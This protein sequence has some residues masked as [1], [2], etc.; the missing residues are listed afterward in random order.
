MNTFQDSRVLY[1]NVAHPVICQGYHFS[2][3]WKTLTRPHH[4]IKRFGSI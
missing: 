2:H 1:I 4:F 3:M